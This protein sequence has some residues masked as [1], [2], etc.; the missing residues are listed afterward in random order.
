MKT[1]LSDWN[2]AVGIS[3]LNASTIAIDVAFSEQIERGARLLEARPEQRAADEQEQDDAHALLLDRIEAG[4]EEHVG[5]VGD[6]DAYKHG[7]GQLCERERIDGNHAAEHQQ[8]DHEDARNQGPDREPAALGRICIVVAMGARG[9]QTGG[10]EV[11]PEQLVLHQ[12]ERHQH[13]ARGE[14]RSPAVVHGQPAR[15]DRTEERAQ[16]DAHVEDREARVAPTAAFRVQIGDHGA[17]VR[18]Q[19]SD[20]ADDDDQAAVER[21]GR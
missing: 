7:A 2:Q 17:D 15:D 20:A 12:A 9:V 11:M 13:A 1:E 14:R 16:V 5:E 18:L 3:K 8:V 19:Q 10:A 6:R 21:R 4:E